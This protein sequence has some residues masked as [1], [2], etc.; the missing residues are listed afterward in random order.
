VASTK[1]AIFTLFEF[2]GTLEVVLGHDL[3]VFRLNPA[4]L[5]MYLFSFSLSFF[6][7]FFLSF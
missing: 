2:K 3:Q 6:L 5:F 1:Q 7:S 4:L